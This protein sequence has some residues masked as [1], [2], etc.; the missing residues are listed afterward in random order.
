MEDW[1]LNRLRQ[2][3]VS[4]KNIQTLKLSYHDHKNKQKMLRACPRV[5]RTVQMDIE[6]PS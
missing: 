3:S 6:A 4:Y 5:G 2:S 1:V